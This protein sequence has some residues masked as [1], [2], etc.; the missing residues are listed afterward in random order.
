MGKMNEW[1]LKMKWWKGIQK[2]AGRVLKLVA[3]DAISS[4][5][6]VG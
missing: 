3:L 6:T 5:E 1:K 2:R 4:S